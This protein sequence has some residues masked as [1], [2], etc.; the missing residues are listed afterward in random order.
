MAEVSAAVQQCYAA[1]QTYTA[2]RPSNL[3][4]QQQSAV[5][6]LT[7]D[8]SIVI[9]PS[10]KNL[11]PVILDTAR[12]N[13]LLDTTLN[14]PA[15]YQVSAQPNVGALRSQLL[16]LLARWQYVMGPVV[17]KYLLTVANNTVVLPQPYAMPKIHKLPAVTVQHLPQL[18]ARVIGPCHSWITSGCSQYLAHLLN[19]A[20]AAKFK[21][22]LPDSRTLVRQLEGKTVARHSILVTFDVVEMYPSIDSEKA[23]RAGAAAAAA[24]QR[25]MVYEMLSFVLGN[26]FLQRGGR[27]YKQSS[28]VIMGTSCAP[29]VANIFMATEFEAK[30]RSITGDNWPDSYFR[31]IDDG[32]FMWQQSS[33]SLAAFVSLLESVI[34][35]IRLQF[36]Y[37]S[38]RIQYLDLWVVKDMSVAGDRVPIKFETFQKPHNRYLYIPYMSHHRPHVFKA[39]IRGELIRYAV[40]NTQLASFQQVSALFRERLLRRGYPTALVTAAFSTASHNNRQQYL[41]GLDTVTDS[42]NAQGNGTAAAAAAFAGV[43]SDNSRNRSAPVLVLT[44]G[45]YEQ[46][47]LNLGQVVNQVYDRFR[48]VSGLQQLFGPRVVVAYRNPPSL[49]RLLVKA[50]H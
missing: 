44:N 6:S 3:S 7:Q 13:L 48:Q 10:D 43:S 46:H 23:A 22:V 8:R 47:R 45:V 2:G 35:G 12:Y 27:V 19:D 18:T 39:F 50:S 37:A 16:A 32:F 5:R 15:Q 20:C 42:S 11:G 33:S 26:S 25:S 31:L 21:H 28:G 34:P 30:A 36:K 1:P 4:A 24:P 29:P 40:T 9:K 41:Q 17:H 49:G 14:D 38:A